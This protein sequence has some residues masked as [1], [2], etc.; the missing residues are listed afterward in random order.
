MTRDSYLQ[1]NRLEPLEAAMEE[2][3]ELAQLDDGFELK[4]FEA[5]LR[6]KS[7]ELQGEKDNAQVMAQPLLMSDNPAITDEAFEMM[8]GVEDIAAQG[9][10]RICKLLRRLGTP[11]V[12]TEAPCAGGAE[13]E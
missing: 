2:I 4:P 12:T 3:K 5:E 9:Q 13:R 6:E 11:D 8:Q 10:R 7:R 1:E